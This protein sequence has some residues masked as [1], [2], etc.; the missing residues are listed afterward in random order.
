MNIF[1]WLLQGYKK[2][3]MLYGY[4]SSNK[5][6]FFIYISKFLI[7]HCNTN[8]CIH[9]MLNSSHAMP[10]STNRARFLSIICVDYFLDLSFLVR[11]VSENREIYPKS[12]NQ[13]IFTFGKVKSEVW[14][15]SS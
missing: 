6:M 8:M 1:L 10:N 3:N 11:K 15:F 13:Q 14:D 7:S 2:K 9:L 4:I 12:R 5:Q